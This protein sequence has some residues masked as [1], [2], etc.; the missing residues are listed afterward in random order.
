MAKGSYRDQVG[1]G[2]FDVVSTIVTSRGDLRAAW[3]NEARSARREQVRPA[4]CG[5]L[6]AQ[7]RRPPRGQP[8]I[9]KLATGP[10]PHLAGRVHTV[11]ALAAQR[12]LVDLAR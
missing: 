9:A 10:P 2:R 5:V 7:L 4:V 1:R 12:A 3:K 6:G 11:P 8:F